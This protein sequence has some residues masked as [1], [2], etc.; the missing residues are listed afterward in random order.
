MCVTH[1]LIFSTQ[2]TRSLHLFGAVHLHIDDEECVDTK[3]PF[4][5]TWERE[6]VT[7]APNENEK[8]FNKSAASAH[9]C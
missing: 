4:G 2:L 7:A 6:N 9:M 3:M 8:F 5:V 1:L